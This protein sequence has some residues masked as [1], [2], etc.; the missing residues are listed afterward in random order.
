MLK[1]L[2]IIPNLRK[3]GAER[4]VLDI[5]IELQQREGIK[6]KI[7]TFSDANE[8]KEISD[9]VDWNII[10]SIY[11]PSITGKS[12]K[13]VAD[14]QMFVDVF[15][16]DIIHSHLWA[17]E[18]VSRQVHY[19]KAKWFSHFHDNMTQLQCLKL[20]LSK[21]NLTNY[22]ERSLMLKKY[23]AYNNSFICIA[24]HSFAYA[25]AMLPKRFK[26]N[27]HLLSN[28]INIER[29]ACK[30]VRVSNTGLLKLVMVGSLV[31]KKNQLFLLKVVQEL[32]KRK[33]KVHL[34]LLGDGPNREM[35]SQYIFS[36][37][38]QNEVTLCGNVDKPEQYYWD[39]DIYVH[40]ATYEPMGLVLLEAMSAGLPVVCL[41]GGG[42]RD[43]IEQGKNGFMLDKQI[44]QLFADR[45]MGLKINPDNY[46][47]MS[48]YAVSYSKK[49]DIKEY[50][51]KLLKLYRS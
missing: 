45:I 24:K 20:P 9:N 48:K 3:G 46:N 2:Q 28:A 35:L 23:K 38:L 4:L 19:P 39:A 14:L 17:A 22:Y 11:K 7:I 6:I 36:N 30:K 18:M 37:N 25:N 29:F 41:D 42:N 27:I 40:S 50:A 26:S 32:K 44:P 8:Y 43:L 15:Q 16:P 47:R 1:V 49:Y 13:N 51:N 31:D 5:C 10:P 21:Q 34:D 33:E 12:T